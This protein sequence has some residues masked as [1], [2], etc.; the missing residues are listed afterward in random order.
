MS[1]DE[2]FVAELARALKAVALEAIVVGS[3][4]AALLGAP[5]LTQDIDI[6]VRDTPR[7]RRKLG[8]LCQALGASLVEIS[9]LTGSRRLVGLRVGIDVLFDEIAGGLRFESLRSRAQKIALPNA[10]VTVASLADI[11]ASKAAAGRP[12]DL[13]QLPI[14]RDTLKVIQAR[15]GTASPTPGRKKHSPAK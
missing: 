5:V 12:K 7:N 9:P 10:Q 6:L 15:T 1:P 8:A 4:G 2:S 11:V 13:A 3:G 14:L